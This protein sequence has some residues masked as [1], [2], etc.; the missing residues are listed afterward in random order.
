M[1]GVG[2]NDSPDLLES[3][4]LWVLYLGEKSKSNYIEVD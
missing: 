4:P 1:E 3:P 2:S